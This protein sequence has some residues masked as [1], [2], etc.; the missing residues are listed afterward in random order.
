M[1]VYYS[2]DSRGITL[3]HGD[4]RPYLETRADESFAA[5]I[6]DPPYTERTHSKFRS[7]SGEDITEG[8]TDFESFN[9]DD[10]AEALAECGRVTRGWVV[11][12]L[13][14]RQAV[15]FD[16]IPPHGLKVQRVGVWVKTNPG[17]QITGDRPAQG[18]EAIA[19]MHRAKG[20]SSWSGGGLAGNFVLP[21]PEATGHP[22][23]KPIVMFRQFVE[24]F[25]QPGDVVLDPFSGGGTTLRAAADLGRGAVGIEKEERFCEITAQ[26]L[27]QQSLAI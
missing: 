20:R 5:V 10:L 12:T 9:D 3:Y 16:V 26:R 18:W 8:I 2:D 21:R 15:M 17:P 1:K 27:E 11:A 22:T 4:S 7:L 14:Y 23:P 13:D 25:T 19:Y 24:W 6:T